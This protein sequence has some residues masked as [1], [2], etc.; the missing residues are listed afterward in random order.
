M[1]VSKIAAILL[2]IGLVVGAG[3]G[4]LGSAFVVYQPQISKLQTDLSDVQSTLSDYAVKLSQLRSDYDFLSSTNEQ[5][6]A[7]LK[8]LNNS[9][10]DLQSDNQKLLVDYTH[11]TENYDKL[12]EFYTKLNLEYEQLEANYDSLDKKHL[13]L[14]DQYSTLEIRYASLESQAPEIATLQSQVSSLQS[15]VNSYKTQVSTLQ[16]S[17]DKMLGITVTQHYEWVYGTLIWSER[18]QWD[19]DI[20]FSIYV[21]YWERPR[22]A[23]WKDWVDMAKDPM[24]DY[25]IS[26]M[27]QKINNV[28]INEGFTEAE[29]VNFVIAFVQNLPY[30]VD[31][32]TT[33]WNEYPRYPIETLFERGGDCED[34]T[35]LTA[36]LLDRM[37]YDVALLFLSYENHVAVGISITGAYGSYYEHNDKKY[38]YL[39]TTGEDWI[40]GQ[41]PPDLTDTRAEIYPLYP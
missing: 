21:E 20:P 7:D 41:I 26:Q 31:E 18:F 14:E 3:S 27:V 15:Q 29:K 30:T 2:I 10:L 33:P 35:I 34:T 6:T 8:Q 5:L 19:L 28:A 4:Y 17:L 9:Y 37:G 32:V 24:D 39:E 40:V 25:Y 16:S 13:D 38:Y 22:P 11:L 12:D 36:A 23:S 1:L